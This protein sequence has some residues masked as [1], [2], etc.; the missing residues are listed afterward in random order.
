[1]L[2]SQPFTFVARVPSPPLRDFVEAI[3]H[4]RG[5]RVNGVERILPD[6]RGTL[7]INVADD[8][9]AT[10]E[11]TPQALRVVPR[12]WLS[13]VQTSP[14]LCRPRGT[15]SLYGVVFR[16]HAIAALFRVAGP[17]SGGQTH[18]LCDVIGREGELLRE[19][20]CEARS[21]DAAFDV[22]EQHLMARLPGKGPHRIAR[23]A[24]VFFESGRIQRIESLSRNLA[25]SRKHLAHVF[26]DELGVPPQEFAR[27]ARFNRSLAALAGASSLAEVAML[28]GYFDQAHFTREF[29]RFSGDTPAGYRAKQ[30]RYF[31]PDAGNAANRHMV[32]ID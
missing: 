20:L 9:E 8:Y 15:T 29:R 3:W 26:R 11:A 28:C 12:S 5:T 22:L 1:M 18:S 21:A 6:C 25:V 2:D 13:G 4:R 27:I 19:R 7:V 32:P 24:P 10:M 31:G 14:I 16:P 17:E 23:I 30:R